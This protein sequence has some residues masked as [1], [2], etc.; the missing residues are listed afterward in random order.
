L[1]SFL[2]WP[3]WNSTRNDSFRRNREINVPVGGSRADLQIHDRQ[4]AFYLREPTSDSWQIIHLALGGDRRFIQFAASGEFAARDRFTA[5]V[6]RKVQIVHVAGEV[7]KLQPA[8]PLESG[9]YALCRAVPGF[10]GSSVCY[11]FGVQR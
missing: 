6:A 7:F 9:E 10:A 4:P 8:A 3:P 5:L 11:G 1:P 2:V